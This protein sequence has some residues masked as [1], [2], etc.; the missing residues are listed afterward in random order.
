MRRTALALVAAALLSL[1]A[2]TRARADDDDAIRR[3]VD[4]FVRRIEDGP[5]PGADSPTAIV[6]RLLSA[7]ETRLRAV[8]AQAWKIAGPTGSSG[9]D[10]FFSVRWTIRFLFGRVEPEGAGEKHDPALSDVVRIG[11]EDGCGSFCGTCNRQ[12]APPIEFGALVG[13]GRLRKPTTPRAGALV[14]LLAG[15][16]PEEFTRPDDDDVVRAIG[17]A[18]ATDAPARTRLLEVAASRDPD[19]RFILAIAWTRSPEAVR[20][21]RGLLPAAAAGCAGGS[22]A[23]RS[24]LAAVCRGLAHIDRAQLNAALAALPENQLDGALGA[25][26]LDAAEPFLSSRVDAARQ[27]ADVAAAYHRIAVVL[28][29]PYGQNKLDF[30]ARLGESDAPPPSAAAAQRMI[31]RCAAALRT[32]DPAARTEALAAAA[33]LLCDPSRDTASSGVS[34]AAYELKSRGDAVSPYPSVEAGLREIGEALAAGHLSV[35]DRW[36]SVFDAEACDREHREF[37]RAKSSVESQFRGPVGREL[38]WPDEQ[39][40]FPGLRLDGDVVDAG[41][42][43]TLT[44]IGAEAVS[45]DPVALR[46]ASAE[47]LTEHV[48]RRDQSAQDYRLLHLLL[49]TSECAITVDATTLVVIGPGKS[50][51]WTI[52]LRPQDRDVEHVAVSLRYDVRVRGAEPAPLVT[53]FGSTWIK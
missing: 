34:C 8:L 48:V 52:A 17:E 45:I 49:G 53:A 29:S 33:T 31:A 36:T 5:Q 11:P 16:R 40:W 41:L 30:V 22:A 39:Q 13:D 9:S 24:T 19:T 21:L 38:D 50:Y 43:L 3:D 37:A 7:D 23:A 47:A 20:F 27:P 6:N 18:C 46:C 44:N 2:P 10:R 32:S 15:Q 12:N 1:I 51:E 28:A 25:A 14:E 4:A 42:R 26:G 35:G